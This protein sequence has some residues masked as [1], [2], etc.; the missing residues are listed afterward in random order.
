MLSSIYLT[1]WHPI[2]AG[3]RQHRRP[4]CPSLTSPSPPPPAGHVQLAQPP[5]RHEPGVPGELD[6]GYVLSQLEELGYSGWVGC[7]YVP[8]TSSEQSLAWIR[9]LGYSL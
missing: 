2:P 5:H 6:F 7:E 4:V 1:L 8:S 3:C 9:G